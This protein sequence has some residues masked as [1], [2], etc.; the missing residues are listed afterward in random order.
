MLLY[1]QLYPDINVLT[2]EIKVYAIHFLHENIKT[3]YPV[4]EKITGN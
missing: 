3:S 2:Q 1:L 4:M